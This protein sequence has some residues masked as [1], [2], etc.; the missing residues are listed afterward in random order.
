MS[1]TRRMG[2]PECDEVLDELEELR[3]GEVTAGEVQSALTAE[4]SRHAMACQECRAAIDDFIEAREGLAAMAESQPQPGPWFVA[5]VMAAVK[6]AENEIEEK[7]LGVWISVRRLA[8]R[9]AAFAGLLLVLGG[10]WAMELRHREAASG[11]PQGRQGEGLF[12]TAPSAPAND[13]IVAS[14]TEGARP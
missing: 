2:R 7:K 9:L 6:A 8:P 12:E 5:R 14:V 1:E 13:D 3:A 10:T 4:S 11:E